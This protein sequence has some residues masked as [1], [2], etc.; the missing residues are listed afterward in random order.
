MKKTALR[1]LGTAMQTYGERLTETGSAH[2]L[3]RCIIDVY[4]RERAAAGRRRQRPAALAVAQLF[5]NDAAGRVEIGALDALAAM[6]REIPP[7]LTAALRRLLK[8]RR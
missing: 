5:V 6:P 3:R 4:A 1:V 8:W 7:V 2:T